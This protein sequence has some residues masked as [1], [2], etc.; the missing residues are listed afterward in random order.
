MVLRYYPTWNSVKL[1]Y[2]KSS[3]RT[4]EI[5]I[6]VKLKANGGEQQECLNIFLILEIMYSIKCSPSTHFMDIRYFITIVMAT[7][8]R[9]FR[10]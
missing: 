3:S 8:A 4:F 6:N 5:K 7:H 2:V 10:T 1:W 9:K